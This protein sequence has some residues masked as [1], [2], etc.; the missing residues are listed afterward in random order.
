MNFSLDGMLNYDISD[1]VK[2]NMKKHE[3]YIIERGMEMKKNVLV[4]IL[5]A[6]VC[7]L[8]GCSAFT[9]Q[10]P[11]ED[12]L[13]LSYDF[14]GST[15]RVTFKKINESQFQASIS[16]GGSQEVVNK[17]LR[18]TDGRIFELGLLGPLWIPPS[19][20]KVG[21]NAHGDRVSEVKRWKG[22]DVGVVKASFGVGGALRGEWYYEKTTGF[23]VGGSKSTALSGEGGGSHFVLKETNLDG[24]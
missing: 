19:S 17:R 2:N 8:T 6:F 13:Y 3:R 9:P 12:G 22:W 23:L 15:I 1:T 14:A 20:V 5:F 10:A 18:T 21:G 4:C 7:L 24:L 16:P 11:L